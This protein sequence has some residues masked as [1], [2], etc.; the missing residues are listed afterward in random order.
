MGIVYLGFDSP[1]TG[2]ELALNHQ[3]KI[4]IINNYKHQTLIWLQLLHEQIF[5]DLNHC[6]VNL[7]GSLV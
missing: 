5:A 4:S 3:T 1:K 6:K 2:F 7:F